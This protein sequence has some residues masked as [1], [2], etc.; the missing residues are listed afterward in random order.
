[1]IQGTVEYVPN[2]RAWSVQC[3]PHVALRLKRVFAGLGKQ[4]RDCYLISDTLDNSR[5]LQWFLSRYPMKVSDPARLSARADAHRESAAIVSN[6]L[7]NQVPARNFDLAIAPREYQRLAASLLLQRNGLLLADDVGLGKTVSAICTFTDTHTLPALVVTMTHLT[8]Q[9]Q[10]E[11]QKFAHGL[12]VHIINKGTPYDLTEVRPKRNGQLAFSRA[13]PNVVIVNYHKL[14]GWAETL[15]RVIRSIVFDECQ[16]LRRRDSRKYEAAKYLAEAAAFR[17][18]L[19]ATPIYNYGAEMY[20]VLDC[21]FPGSLGSIGEFS[22]EWC[23]GDSERIAHPKA[24]STYLRESGMMLRRTRADVGRELPTVSKFSH[25]IEADEKALDQ[26]SGNCAELAR[27]IL[28]V[29]EHGRG[30][31]MRASEELSNALL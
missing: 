5:D 15:S 13:F 27:M 3:E 20:S 18:G 30:D 8:W 11:V 4:T 7:A 22:T 23:A 9:W 26:V 29:G 2:L 31:K 25:Q 12:S 6:L 17:L 14:S 1:M 28:A 21:L 24:F 19:S 10:A 16:E